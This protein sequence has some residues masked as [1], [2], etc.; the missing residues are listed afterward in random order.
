[1]ATALSLALLGAGCSCNEPAGS[2]CPAVFQIGEACTSLGMVCPYPGAKCGTSCTCK[3]E[4]GGFVWDCKVSNCSC[5]CPCGQVAIASCEALE[6]AEQQD[7]CPAS[8]AA[9]CGV[10]C[11]DGGRPE[12]GPRDA[13]VERRDAAPDLRSPDRGPDAPR[14]SAIDQLFDLPLDAKPDLPVDAAPDAPFDASRGAPDTSSPDLPP[15]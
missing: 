3:N 12:A 15:G 6:C 7:P 2:E 11:A 5:T 4:P 9:I 14:D 10:I 8:A 13:G 1:L